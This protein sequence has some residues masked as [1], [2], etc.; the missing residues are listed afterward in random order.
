MNNQQY[1]QISSIN[2]N[3]ENIHSEELF[4]SNVDNKRTG[5][6][7]TNKTK[8]KLSNKE[9]DKLMNNFKK[10]NQLKL[11]KKRN[12]HLEKHIHA[13]PNKIRK[14][15][16]RKKT[17]KRKNKKLKGGKKEP[18]FTYNIIHKRLK[19]DICKIDLNNKK[20]IIKIVEDLN[21]HIGILDLPLDDYDVASF[22]KYI[23]NKR[24]KL[25]RTKNYK[26]CRSQSKHFVG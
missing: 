13:K 22:K 23:I 16:N 9:I 2:V 5:Y 1:H 20:Q 17:K 7:K 4:L 6:I 3:N 24:K 21:K 11:S 14:K 18:D 15:S 12:Y 26:Y 25:K 19:K 8:K 10:S